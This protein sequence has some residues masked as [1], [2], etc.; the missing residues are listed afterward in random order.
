MEKVT[1]DD[2]LLWSEVEML[3]GDNNVYTLDDVQNVY[4]IMGS[5]DPYS[6]KMFE[7]EITRGNSEW[8]ATLHQIHFGAECINPDTVQCTM[9]E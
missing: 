5:L 2:Q 1:E 9:A 6:F 8:F 4:A 7:K 3:L